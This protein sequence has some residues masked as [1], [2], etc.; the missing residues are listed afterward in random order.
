M[1]QQADEIAAARSFYACAL[2]ALQASGAPFMVGGA[3]G[4]QVYTGIARHTKD[5]DIFCTAGAYPH[6]LEALARAGYETQI[7]DANWLAKAFQ[8]DF[9]I[10][11]IFDSAN[12]LV[13]IEDYWLE[14][15]VMA[16]LFGCR[17][18]I[19]PI[20]ELIWSKL[21]VDDRFRFDGADVNHLILAQGRTLDWHRLLG[22]MDRD[23]ELLMSHL[24]MF[25]F[26]YPSE[27]DVIPDWLANELLGRLQH[28]L[29]LPVPQDRVSRGP[30]LSRTQ[31]QVDIDRW[32]FKER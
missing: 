12:G 9:F 19:V 32:G 21:Y 24:L 25:R 3:Y 4:L 1:N 16:D 7:T 6:L 14:D 29:E 2:E 26:V 30:L 10:D 5:L 11:L 13:R 8:G 28:Q 27:V 31:Y 23:W 17:V 22:H 15:A 18:P 20:V